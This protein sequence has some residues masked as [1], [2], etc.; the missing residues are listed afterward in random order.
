MPPGTSDSSSTYVF[1]GFGDDLPIASY[2]DMVSYLRHFA[3]PSRITRL[4]NALPEERPEAWAEF[5]RE[6]D[7]DPKTA[8]HEDLRAYFARL[9]RSNVRFR[10]ETTPG[11]MSDRGR[12]FIALGEPDV[13]HEPPGAEFARGRQQIWEYQNLNLQ[14]VFY[15]QTGT[16]RWRLTPSSEGRFEQ[17]YRRRLK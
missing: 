14:I 13:L 10:E 2:E 7:S 15:D 4:R 9:I 1:V 16:G 11:W 12:V 8:I 3:Q 6:T 17:E 5:V